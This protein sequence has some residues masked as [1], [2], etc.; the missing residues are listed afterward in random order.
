VVGRVCSRSRVVGDFLRVLFSS[1]RFPAARLPSSGAPSTLLLSPRRFAAAPYTPFVRVVA[2]LAYARSPRRPARS[3]LEH[4]KPERHPERATRADACAPSSTHAAIKS[5]SDCIFV[6]RQRSWRRYSC[7]NFARCKRSQARNAR[8]PLRAP[9]GGAGRP[10]RQP[11]APNAQHLAAQHA[12]LAHGLLCKNAS[13]AS[14]Q[15]PRAARRWTLPWTCL[16][17]RC[18]SPP[19]AARYTLRL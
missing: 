18:R 5:R 13:S 1:P 17:T 4:K 15:G 19:P 8:H 6:W 2:A 12:V 10:T 9:S 7:E 11:R 16:A 14:S 3:L